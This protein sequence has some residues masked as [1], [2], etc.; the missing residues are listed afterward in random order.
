MGEQTPVCDNRECTLSKS[1]AVPFIMSLKYDRD[2]MEDVTSS[3]WRGF[4]VYRC[5]ACHRDYIKVTDPRN[6][7]G[8][9]QY[10]VL[11]SHDSGKP[12][13]KSGEDF[14]II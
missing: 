1:N 2:V 7:N 10:F 9:S 14:K 6:M 8:L 11:K 3:K 13:L 12:T 4:K 5:V